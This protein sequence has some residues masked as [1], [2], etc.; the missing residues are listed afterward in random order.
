MKQKVSPQLTRCG[1]DSSDWPFFFFFSNL[2]LRGVVIVIGLGGNDENP[3]SAFRGE[4]DTHLKCASMNSE[5][6]T[7]ND[8]GVFLGRFLVL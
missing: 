5:D 3:G 4:V 2:F 1:G 7:A 6:L 8:G